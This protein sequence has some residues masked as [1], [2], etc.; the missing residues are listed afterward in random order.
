MFAGMTKSCAKNA[1]G[2]L[3]WLFFGAGQTE[4]ANGLSFA[5]WMGRWRETDPAKYSERSWQPHG[6]HWAEAIEQRPILLCVGWHGKLLAPEFFT[7]N[8]RPCLNFL[9]LWSGR[10]SISI[11]GLQFG[12]ICKHYDGLSS[13]YHLQFGR[14]WLIVIHSALWVL[15]RNCVAEP[16]SW[17]SAVLAPP[18]GWIT[19]LQSWQPHESWGQSFRSKDHPKTI[20]QAVGL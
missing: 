2:G 11:F 18:S 15:K 7:Q 3:V 1:P 12:R 19:S 13:L 20:L 4:T 5:S 17:W 16:H 6:S 10:V 9:P 14:S 8:P